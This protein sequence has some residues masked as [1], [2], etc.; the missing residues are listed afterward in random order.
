MVGTERLG[1]AAITQW[2]T[3]NYTVEKYSL[4]T[5]KVFK[6]LCKNFAA[7]GRKFHYIREKISLHTGE[8]FITYG[9]KFYYIREKISLHTGENVFTIRRSRN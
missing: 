3:A 1:S 6:T 7:Y 8:N 5:A 4:P 2:G 9:R